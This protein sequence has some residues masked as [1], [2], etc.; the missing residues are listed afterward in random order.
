MINQEDLCE[1]VISHAVI[2]QL[3]FNKKKDSTDGSSP[4]VIL[5]FTLVDFHYLLILMGQGRV[6]VFDCSNVLKGAAY[7]VRFLND[8]QISPQATTS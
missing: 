6:I 2:E 3:G 5:D 8:F 1:D 7:Q 4:G